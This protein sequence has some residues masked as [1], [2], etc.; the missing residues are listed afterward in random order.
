VTTPALKLDPHNANRGT[1]RGRRAVAD[2]LAECGA[3]RSILVDRDG[4]VIAGNKTLEAA[5]AM[6]LPVRVV[7]SSGDELV[8]VQRT[9]LV[10]DDAEDQRARRLAYLDN[11]AAQLGLD[12]DTDQ[13]LADLE[14]GVDLSG[15]WDDTELDELLQ[16]VA[17]NDGLT[18][19]DDVPEVPA[20]ATTQPGDLWL[21]GEHRVLCGD[22]SGDLSRLF[23]GAVAQLVVTSPPYASQRKYDEA[24]GFRPIAPE[25]YEEWFEPIQANIASV[26]APDGSYLLNIKEH[27]EDGQRH[28]YV[29]D[30]TIAHVR[31]WGWRFVDEFCWRD[32]NNGVPGAWPNRF[33][34]AWE[35]VFHFSLSAEIKFRPLANASDSDAV[36]AYSPDTAKTKTGSGL[37]GAKATQEKHG[38]ARPSNVVEVAAASSGGHS[39]AYPVALPAWFVRAF[40]DAG[41]VVFDPFLGSGTTLIA[42]EQTGRVCY[43]T[44]LSPR[45]V[46]VIVRRWEEFT[47]R[48]AVLDG[49]ESHTQSS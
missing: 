36:F 1:D 47:G 9:D 41:D 27:C 13:I 49:N 14:A 42:A 28:L 37:L 20:E 34:D 35:P 6:G 24:S 3:G 12:W 29:K 8:V 23:A 26:L 40:T 2:S 46:D 32:S 17:G 43:G 25:T 7:E 16:R 19:P 38:K 48:K 18:D 11:R 44:E 4:T 39:A 15:L 5:Q 33:K 30:L 21:L 31:K 45:Y 22:A 10:L